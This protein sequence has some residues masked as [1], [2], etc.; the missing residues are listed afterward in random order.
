MK[1]DAAIVGGG[2]AGLAAAKEIASRGGTVVVIDENHRWGGKLLGQLHEEPKSGTW[3]KG[4]E[5]ASRLVNE[6][7]EAGA[8]LISKTLVWGL[9]K[10]W[11]VYTSDLFNR[12]D[13]QKRLEAKALLLATGAVEKP[14]PIPGWTLP[15]VMTVGAAQ[16]LT[17]LYRVKPGKRVLVVGLDVLSLTIARAMKLAGVD[18]VG[19]VLPLKTAFSEAIANPQKRLQAFRTMVD[20]A[21]NPL[22]RMGGRF[23]RTDWGVNLAARF[24]PPWGMTVWGIPLLLKKALI[25]VIGDQQVEGVRIASIDPQGNVIAGSEKILSVDAVCL[26]GGLTPLGELAATVGCQFVRLRGLNGAVPLHGPTMETTV[27][28]LFVAGNIT[29][30]EGA[31]IAIEQGRLAGLGI[32]HKLG[33]GQVDQKECEQ[34]FERIHQLRKEAEISFHPEVQQAREQLLHLWKQKRDR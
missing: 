33:I 6:A 22:M 20:L 8:Q 28:N 16:V 27:D 24:Y 5:I 23:L 14:L 15:G 34:Q 3:W 32:C 29:G 12:P 18:V 10:G 21:P 7:K 9:E 25:E 11:V 17:N 1:V 2:P 4:A 30:I 26:S 31:K 13:A 19:L